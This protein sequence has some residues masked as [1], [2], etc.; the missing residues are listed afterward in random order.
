MPNMA[1]PILI[2]TGPVD[3]FLWALE[4]LASPSLVSVYHNAPFDLGHLHRAGVKVGGTIHDTLQMLR[5][6]DQDRGGDGAD[7]KT[8]RRYL[9]G[10]PEL[11]PF[12]SYRLKDCVP[13]LVLVDMIDFPGS[14]AALPYREHVSYLASDLIGTRALYDYL[15]DRLNQRPQLRDYYDHLCA[16]LTPLLVEMTERGMLAD[17]RFIREETDRLNDLA[18]RLAQQHLQT[19]G[20]PIHDNGSVARWL[21]GTLKLRRCRGNSSGRAVAGSPPLTPTILTAFAIDTPTIPASPAHST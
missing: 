6:L 18:A 11:N 12:T 16:P 2:I 15:L 21:W 19:Y 3:R 4:P 10:D 1:V 8:R 7:V 17:P 5:L 13:R 20:H 9:T 14:V